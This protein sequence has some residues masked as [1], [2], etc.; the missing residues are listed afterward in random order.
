MV[1][2]KR[3]LLAYNQEHVLVEPLKL[4]DNAVHFNRFQLGMCFLV[5]K[6][7]RAIRRRRRD[8]RVRCG[9]GNLLSVRGFKLIH[10]LELL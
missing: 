7:H 1:V 2:D 5:E 10:D 9:N 4:R 3:L 6:P 8:E